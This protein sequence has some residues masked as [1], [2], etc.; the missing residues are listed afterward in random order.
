MRIFHKIM[1]KIRIKNIK[2]YQLF[3]RNKYM[4]HLCKVYSKYGVVFENGKPRYISADVEFDNSNKIYIG[5]NTTIAAKTCILTHDYSVDYG[6]MHNTELKTKYDGKE[7]C[8]LKEVHIGDNC[9][10]GQ[11]VIILPGVV[12]GKNSIVGAGSVVT[13]NIP[14]N[15]VYAGNPAKFICSIQDYSQKIIDKEQFFNCS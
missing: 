15:C 11:R 5:K 13:K 9:F 2:Y 7:I 14:E 6:I 4:K 10:I 3:G 8:I 1:K 12:I